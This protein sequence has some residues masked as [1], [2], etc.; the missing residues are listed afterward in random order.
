VR[1]KRSNE[2]VASVG[3]PSVAESPGDP[4]HPQRQPIHCKTHQVRIALQDKSLCTVTQMRCTMRVY[5]LGRGCNCRA[6]RNPICKCCGDD[7]AALQGTLPSTR[8]PG[9]SASQRGRDVATSDRNAG[10]VIGKMG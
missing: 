3:A 10:I 5:V 9:L 6:T 2:T 1:A 8:L 7:H 4:V